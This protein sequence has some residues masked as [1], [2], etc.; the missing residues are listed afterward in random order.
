MLDLSAALFRSRSTLQELHG[1]PVSAVPSPAALMQLTALRALS[2]VGRLDSALSLPT[3]L[4]S[5]RVDNL[6]DVK[7]SVVRF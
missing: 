4:R 3:G 1:L 5:L 2:L 7:A 6:D